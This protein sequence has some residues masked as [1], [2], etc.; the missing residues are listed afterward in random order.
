M[1]ILGIFM[2]FFTRAG[3]PGES[4]PALN[5]TKQLLQNTC[6]HGVPAQK[7]LVRTSMFHE[8]LRMDEN[9]NRSDLK[10]LY[11]AKTNRD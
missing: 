5:V 11:V 10:F 4:K 8:I 7:T 2:R 3:K 1:S 9:L 6:W